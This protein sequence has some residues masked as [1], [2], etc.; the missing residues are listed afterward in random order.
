MLS[1]NNT[2]TKV[3][4]GVAALFVTIGTTYYFRSNIGSLFSKKETPSEE[5]S[6]IEKN[7]EEKNETETRVNTDE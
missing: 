5:I 4:L 6:E 7:E 3:G 1:V 2:Q